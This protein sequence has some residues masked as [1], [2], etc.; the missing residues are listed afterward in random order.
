M[1]CSVFVLGDDTMDGL[2]LG[3]LVPGTWYVSVS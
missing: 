2:F 1:T 3:L